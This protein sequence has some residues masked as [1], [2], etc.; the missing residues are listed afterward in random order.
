M[1][2]RPPLN[3]LLVESS[4]YSEDS[5][6]AVSHTLTGIE[7]GTNSNYFP[8][9]VLPMRAGDAARTPTTTVIRP[10]I[11][12]AAGGMCSVSDYSEMEDEERKQ[13]S[14]WT[15]RYIWHHVKFILCEEDADLNSN[16]AQLAFHKVKDVP[17][18]VSYWKRNQDVYIKSMQ[19]KRA[20]C[21][22]AVKESFMGKYITQQNVCNTST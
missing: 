2:K 1:R 13:A 19:Q 10:N 6:T 8:G 5:S 4:S 17:C 9:A 18:K 7:A 21:T 12:V 16:L 22:H 15:R 14:K 3:T 20:A 11:P